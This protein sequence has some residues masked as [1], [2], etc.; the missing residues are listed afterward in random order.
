MAHSHRQYSWEK[1]RDAAQQDLDKF[2]TNSK[3]LGDLIDFLKEETKGYSYSDKWWKLCQGVKS[4]N[5]QKEIN[6]MNDSELED[7]QDE[8]E[9]RLQKIKQER[10]TR[11]INQAYCVICK[12][13]PKNVGIL[14][15]KHLDLCAECESKLSS[16]KCPRCSTNYNKIIIIKR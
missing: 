8:L 3:K 9:E 16:K 2:A 5:E 1:Y 6:E 11:Y 15:C 14:K 7:L 10:Q 4:I 12:I 13:N